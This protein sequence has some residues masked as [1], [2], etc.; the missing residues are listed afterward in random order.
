MVSPERVRGVILH[1]LKLYLERPRDGEDQGDAYMLTVN[2]QANLSQWYRI[3]LREGELTGYLTE[4]K[5]WGFALYKELRA[6]PP[7]M[8]HT[9]LGWRITG[10]GMFLLRGERAD[11]R[12]AVPRW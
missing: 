7:P 10:D 3:T 11:P 2:L 5:D 6:G 4:L 9:E 12:I 1:V 8:T